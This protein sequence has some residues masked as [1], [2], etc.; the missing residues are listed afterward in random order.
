MFGSFGDM[1][2]CCLWSHNFVTRIF[3]LWWCCVVSMY[4]MR[5]ESSGVLF[6]VGWGFL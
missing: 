3:L 2:A 1:L 5:C 4:I 6:L